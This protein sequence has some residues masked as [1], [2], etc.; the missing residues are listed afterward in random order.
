M[1]G[2]KKDSL[3]HFFVDAGAGREDCS[4]CRVKLAAAGD[5][6]IGRDVQFVPSFRHRM[7]QRYVLAFPSMTY[8]QALEMID[9]E[10][11]ERATGRVEL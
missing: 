4:D 5:P 11:A 7:A 6:T 2:V 10:L 8:L 1:S 9:R 3:G